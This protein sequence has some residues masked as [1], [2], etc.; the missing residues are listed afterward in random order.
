MN[1]KPF[2]L[3]KKGERK[4]FRPR[5]WSHQD[6]LKHMRGKTI[7]IT[8]PGSAGDRCVTGTL[9]E[10]DQ[11]TLKIQRQNDQAILTYFK[12]HLIAFQEV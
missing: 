6:D 10:S 2:A 5:A 7:K 9:M 3:E 11:F 4:P 1:R 12:S 8:M